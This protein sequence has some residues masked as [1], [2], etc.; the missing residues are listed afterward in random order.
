MKNSYFTLLAILALGMIAT[1]TV[2]GCVERNMVITSEP[3]GADIWVNDQWHGKTPFELPFKHYGV[4]SIRLEAEGYY[5]M[6][7]KEPVAAPAYERLGIDLISEAAIP[8]TIHDERN[9]HY[10]M[11]KIESPDAIAEVLERADDMI[12]RTDEIV[13]NRRVYDSQRD[14]VDLPLLPQAVEGSDKDAEDIRKQLAV[15]TMDMEYKKG[16]D[17]DDLEP[18][19]DIK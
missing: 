11:Q 5:P 2:V 8:A 14:P 7:V 4:F 6:Y 15:D 19:G 10:V 16:K 9:M 3:S 1:L 13:T 12:S 18:L 17:L